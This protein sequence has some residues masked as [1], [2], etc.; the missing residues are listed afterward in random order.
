MQEKQYSIL[1][2][3]VSMQLNTLDHKRDYAKT[4]YYNKLVL[5]MQ[6]IH[7]SL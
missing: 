4:H 3:I 7:Y 1:T 6:D 5:Y 2:Y